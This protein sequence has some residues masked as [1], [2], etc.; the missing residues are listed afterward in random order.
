MPAPLLLCAAEETIVLRLLGPMPC[1]QREPTGPDPELE[2]AAGPREV[3]EEVDG[4]VDD[5]R[6]LQVGPQHVVEPGDPLVEVGLRHDGTV[7][8]S[9][10][11]SPSIWPLAPVLPVGE[12][13]HVAVGV[14]DH[15]PP[16]A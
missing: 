8:A 16:I 5:A 2:R 1:P 3:G 7:R 4:R 14:A 6:I 12:L 9:L 10:A 13:E 11:G 15:G